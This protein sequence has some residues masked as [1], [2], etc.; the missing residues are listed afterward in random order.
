LTFGLLPRAE[1]AIVNPAYEYASAGT[2][3]DDRP[4]TL[5]FEFSLSAPETVDALGYTT[6]GFAS[7]QTVGIWDSDGALLTSS[8]L[9][10]G[11]PVVG[12][13]AWSAI[14]PLT[15]G[16]GTYTIGGTYDGGLLPSF[17][18]GVTSIPGYTWIE[19][20]QANGAGLSDPTFSAG[21]YGANGIPQVDFSVSTTAIP[22][23]ATWITLILGL[24]FCG[25]LARRRKSLAV[26]A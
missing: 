19:D 7:N 22:E 16:P 3:S 10:T 18:S 11:D 9:S 5:G 8:K 24:V 2:Y 12:H 6:V 13:F 14:A 26:F 23:P 20:E 17:A 25:I 1:A 15:L 4:F 21:G